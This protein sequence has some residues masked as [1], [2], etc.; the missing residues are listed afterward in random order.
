MDKRYLNILGKPG[1][2]PLELFWDRVDQ[3][4][5]HLDAKIAVAEESIR[6]LEAPSESA[7]EA[8]KSGK[9]LVTPQSTMEEFVSRV[10]RD[11]ESEDKL[12][13]EDLYEVFHCVSESTLLFLQLILL[14]YRVT[15]ASHQETE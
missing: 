15:R 9:M 7:E 14:R 1:S 10:R 8:A 2:N 5:Q 3:L 12:S 4:D 11:K 13:D 6:K